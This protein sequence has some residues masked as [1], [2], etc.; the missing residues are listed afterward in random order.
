[1]TDTTD[2]EIYMRLIDA[3]KTAGG[4]AQQLAHSRKDERWLW[5]R[6]IMEVAVNKVALLATRRLA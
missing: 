2:K 1:M 6:D 3:L 5:V 4:C